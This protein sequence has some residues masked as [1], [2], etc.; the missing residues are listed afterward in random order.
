M[1]RCGSSYGWS[2]TYYFRALPNDT[3][4]S[5]GLRFAVFGDMGN[6]NAQSLSRLQVEAQD[7]MYDAVLHVGEFRGFMFRTQ[8]YWL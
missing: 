8:T 2:S 3:Q 5:K 1:Y 4:A 7:G 6:D